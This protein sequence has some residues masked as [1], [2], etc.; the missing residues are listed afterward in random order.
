MLERLIHEYL[1]REIGQPLLTLSSLNKLIWFDFDFKNAKILWSSFGSGDGRLQ[2]SDHG[3]S[4]PA[5]TSPLY[6]KDNFFTYNLSDEDDVNYGNTN[7]NETMIVAVVIE[8]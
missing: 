5:L 7:L 8:I 3:V 4:L 6:I 1:A 2:E